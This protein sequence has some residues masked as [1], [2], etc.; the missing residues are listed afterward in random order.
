MN[1]VERQRRIQQ[2]AMAN[3]GSQPAI[4]LVKT[5]DIESEEADI[6]YRVEKFNELNKRFEK[7]RKEQWKLR[8]NDLRYNL[9]LRKMQK[10]S[11]MDLG[12]DLEGY[13]DFVNNL[14]EFA[15]YNKD[16]E[17]LAQD[18]MKLPDGTMWTQY[19]EHTTAELMRSGAPID[20]D[21]I[22]EAREIAQTAAKCK[23]LKVTVLKLFR[24]NNSRLNQKDIDI[25]SQFEDEPFSFLDHDA[26]LTIQ[27]KRLYEKRLQQ[28]KERN[29]MNTY[30]IDQVTDKDLERCG[31]SK[32]E[33]DLIKKLMKIDRLMFAVREFKESSPYTYVVDLS[34]YQDQKIPQECKEVLFRPAKMRKLYE[35]YWAIASELDKQAA[36]DKLDAKRYRWNS[37]RF[38]PKSDDEYLLMDKIVETI[39]RVVEQTY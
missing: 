14:K 13:Q 37:Q 25:V 34:K 28:V 1:I 16:F 32:R 35:R 9:Y 2:E 22:D 29:Q 39:D 31:V 4:E 27:I 5:D 21:E 23:Q 7:H 17:I 36:A 10:L 38:L 24:E 33:F 3:L 18:N 19:S 12:L 8:G 30:H 15:K 11:R 26:D 20:Q 6:F